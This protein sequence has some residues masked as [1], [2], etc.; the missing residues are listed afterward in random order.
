MPKE[1]DYEFDLI[2]GLSRVRIRFSTDGVTVAAFLA[3]L[4]ALDDNEWKP[5]QRYD[6]YHGQPHRDYLDRWGCEYKKVWLDIDRNTALTM[7]I[8]DFRENGE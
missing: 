8:Q 2:V 5:V 6:D 1:T 7:A 3:Q 4:E